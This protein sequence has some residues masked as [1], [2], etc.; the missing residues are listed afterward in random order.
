MAL[1]WPDYRRLEFH[2]PHTNICVL[3]AA[4][5]P[6]RTHSQRIAPA[7]RLR[8]WIS[9]S[10]RHHSFPSWPHSTCAT[11]ER[12]QEQC[13]AHCTCNS[14]HSDWC[15]LPYSVRRLGMA[16][17]EIS[18]VSG[19]SEGKESAG[20]GYLV[21]CDVCVWSQFLRGTSEPNQALE[22]LHDILCTSHKY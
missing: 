21:T 4:T 15:L 5:T 12:R 18:N 14:D 20:I 2:W 6:D 1:G 13:L 11:T 22:L 3:L 8:R 17:R 10:S 19:P 7:H 16:L 9:I